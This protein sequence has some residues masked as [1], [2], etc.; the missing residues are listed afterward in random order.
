MKRK[1]DTVLKIN[2]HLPSNLINGTLLWIDASSKKVFHS[3]K[4]YDAV[5]FIE[6]DSN[7]LGESEE[8][9]STNKQKLDSIIKWLDGTERIFGIYLKDT[10][11]QTEAS[12][13][14]IIAE[15]L[16]FSTWEKLRDYAEEYFKKYDQIEVERK[17]ESERRKQAKKEWL[18]RGRRFLRK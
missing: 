6:H 1:G 4:R 8:V 7:Y 9:F 11:H 2:I 3:S 10:N 16:F 13:S 5:E 18:E 15:V 12:K 17:E 14:T